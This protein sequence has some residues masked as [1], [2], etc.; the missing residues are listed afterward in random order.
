MQ[1]PC[2]AVWDR[3]TVIIYAVLYFGEIIKFVIDF[4]NTIKPV[5]FVD[6]LTE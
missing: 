5:N 6:R 3:A 2:I 1:A 4:I